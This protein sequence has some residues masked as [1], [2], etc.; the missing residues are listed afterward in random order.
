[1]PR[2]RDN[3]AGRRTQE[4]MEMADIVAIVVIVILAAVVLAAA[5]GLEKL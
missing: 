3:P 2:H 4:G 5:I 1:V